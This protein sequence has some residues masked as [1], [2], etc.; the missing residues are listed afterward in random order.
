MTKT[1]ITLAIDKDARQLID[2]YAGKRAIGR[3]FADLVRKHHFEE[4]Y[5]EEI[6]KRR[7]DRIEDRLIHLVENK[8]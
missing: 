2:Q 5:G 3:F 1:R 6:I 4:I 8:V 7:L